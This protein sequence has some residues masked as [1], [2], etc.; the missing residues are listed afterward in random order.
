MIQKLNKKGFTIVELMLSM[1][2]VSVLLISI[3]IMGMQLSTIYIKGNTLKDL[4]AAGRTINDDFTHTFNS[5]ASI[6]W[7]GPKTSGSNYIVS[8]KAGAF[9]TGGYSYL[10]NDAAALNDDNSAKAIRYKGSNQKDDSIR[11]IRVSDTNGNY[12]S[13]NYSSFWDKVPKDDAGSNPVVDLLPAGENGLMVYG[14]KFFSNDNMEDKATNQR[15]I[16]IS[17]ILGTKSQKDS[18]NGKGTIDV[19]GMKCEPPATSDAADYCAI[20][21]FEITVRTLGKR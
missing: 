20:N 9:C 7:S 14:I 17:Y 19:V 3:A 1:S 21:K 2:F 12:C 13:A 6:D 10:W 16:T 11:L 4:N 8:N 15:A 5:L 18:A